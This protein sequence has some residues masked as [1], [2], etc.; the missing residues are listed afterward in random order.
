MK[1]VR[2]VADS[3]RLKVEDISK[4]SERV[5]ELV[6]AL[7]KEIRKHPA[8]GDVERLS[9]GSYYEGV[10]FERCPLRN[11]FVRYIQEI[12]KPN[13][14]DIMLKIPLKSVALDP[15]ECNGSAF[16][17]VKLESGDPKR[18]LLSKYLDKNGY[19][20]SSEMLLQ[21]R[22]IVK[23]KIDKETNV[24]VER[25]KPRCPAV[26]LCIED[27]PAISVDI[28]LALE[29]E[30]H[31]PSNTE[32]GLKI[33]PWL[34]STVRDRFRLNPFYLVP[35]Q[36]NNGR[37]TTDTW[38]ISFSHVEKEM[39]N[40]HGNGKTCCE[41]QEPR[42]CRKFCLRLLKCLLQNLQEYDKSKKLDKFCSYHVKTTFF[43]SCVSRPTDQQW[44]MND[45]S[46]CFEM[47]LDDFVERLKKRDL[48]HF[49]IPS[50]N[51]FDS[52]E[53]DENNFKSLLSNIE[54]ERN[55]KFPIF[56]LFPN[57]I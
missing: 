24:S 42:C 45:L 10:K 31:W 17:Y 44:Q 56:Q 46:E 3:L 12:S 54:Y 36:A 14:F 40:N 15:F 30:Q 21:L 1:T 28:V 2:E 6:D 25:K 37:A 34:G 23:E 47:F 41:S 8:F 35:K 13:E 53:I 7:V 33:E 5:N 19:L 50:F 39:L 57:N 27:N 51:L 11:K 38:R 43:H 52:R 18:D 48:P 16:Y 29:V 20:S 32:D 22:K 49:F 4:A 55:N 9:T 26:T